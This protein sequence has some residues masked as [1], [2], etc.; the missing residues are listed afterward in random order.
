MIGEELD[1]APSEVMKKLEGLHFAS[2]RFVL[3]PLLQILE[4]DY[5]ESNW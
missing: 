4:I 3:T 2:I 5:C 1:R